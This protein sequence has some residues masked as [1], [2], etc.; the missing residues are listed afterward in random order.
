M[1]KKGE[2]TRLQLPKSRLPMS[3]LCC[4]LL[5]TATLFGVVQVSGVDHNP[6]AGEITVVNE[7]DVFFDDSYVHEIRLYFDDPNWYDT[8][9]AGHDDDRNTADPYFPARFVSHGIELG[10]VGVRFKGLSTFGFNF[11]GSGFFF[12]PGGG[13]EDTQIKKPF[14]I[15]FNLY[16]E[17]DGEETTFFGLKKLNLNNGALDPSMIREKLF[18]DFASNYVPAPRSVYTR[19]YV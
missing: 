5:L 17:G 7:A 13:G 12:G 2:T 9:Y 14:R 1:V 15:D 11:G 6:W 4:A 8:L 18:M 10:P 19:L 16:D 3:V